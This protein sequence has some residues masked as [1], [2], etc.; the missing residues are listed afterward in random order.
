MY[1]IRS[2]YDRCNKNNPGDRIG[3]MLPKKNDTSK[4]RALLHPA[5]L[6]G[7]KHRIEICRDI[8][9]HRRNKVGP[10]FF[11][12]KTIISVDVRPTSTAFRITS[13]NVCYTK[14]L[15]WMKGYNARK[16]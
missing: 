11:G 4:N 2:Y 12:F 5:K 14:L 6:I 13:Y 15:R 16:F 3:S 9:N 7:D 10:A 1:A 8:R